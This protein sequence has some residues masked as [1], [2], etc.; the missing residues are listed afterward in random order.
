M[1]AAVVGMAVALW[2]ATA[3]PGERSVKGWLNERAEW[4]MGE[5][6]DV[7]GA[8]RGI[9]IGMVVGVAI[10]AGIFAALIWGV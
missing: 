5:R 6:D 2:V 9:V 8:A 3:E 1:I 4:R 7:G 10:W